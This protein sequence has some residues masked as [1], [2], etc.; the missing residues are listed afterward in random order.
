MNGGILKR[1]ITVVIVS[2]IPAF[3]SYLANSS[4]LFDKMIEFG[5]LSDS[6]D[7]PLVQDYCLW[8]G[9]VFSAIFISINLFIKS[10]NLDRVSEQRNSLISM[11]KDLLTSSLGKR[12]LSESCPF[13][14][15]IFIPKHPFL[16]KLTDQIKFIKIK[17]KFIIKNIDLIANQGITKDLQFEVYPNQEGLVGSCY[18]TKSMV[19]DDDL[20]NTNSKN[21]QLT[22]NQQDRTS[23][24]K[25]SICCPICDEND[26]VVAIIALDG[27]TRITIDKEKEIEI[28]EQMVSFSRMLYDSVPQLFTRWF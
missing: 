15:R 3:L 28:R 10:V 27:N 6:I 1:F 13:D 25:W 5:L 21:Y 18:K 24:L 4:L 22:Q 20:E 9:I 11:M 26:I 17:K 2:A 19:Y 8:I 12:F 7:I 14:I 23:K 16:Y